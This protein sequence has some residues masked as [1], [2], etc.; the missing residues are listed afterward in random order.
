MEIGVRIISK[1]SAAILAN[2]EEY[3]I[4]FIIYLGS[5]IRFAIENTK[6]RNYLYV[7]YMYEYIYSIY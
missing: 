3:R 1:T 2:T 4:N 6:R 7:P 5:S